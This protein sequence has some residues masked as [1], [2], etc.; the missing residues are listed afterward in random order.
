MVRSLWR[1][2]MGPSRDTNMAYISRPLPRDLPDAQVVEALDRALAANSDPAY[3]VET[4]PA[5]LRE[6][7]GRD[8]EVLDRSVQDV[9]GAYMRRAVMIRDGDV[10]HWP[11]Y[12]AM[13]YSLL[14]SPEEAAAARAALAEPPSQMAGWEPPPMPGEADG[15]GGA[16]PDAGP[17]AGGE[18]SPAPADTQA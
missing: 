15:S 17:P 8:F 10:G 9:T 6:V 11:G 12:D 7:T 14:A 1:T 16:A 4:L 13:R 3:L 18:A 5:A 2:L